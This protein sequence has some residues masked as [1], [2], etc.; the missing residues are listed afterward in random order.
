MNIK[1]IQ[2]STILAIGAL[3]GCGTVSD[4][5]GADNGGADIPG[6]TGPVAV[7]ACSN[8]NDP[9][10]D[11]QLATA[12][13]QLQ[14][15]MDDM[16]QA[17]SDGQWSQVQ[18]SAPTNAGASY[19]AIL[20]KYPG[21]CGAQFG[22]ALVTLANL[23]N[24]PDLDE[25]IDSLNQNSEDPS[26][27]QYLDADPEGRETVLL[28]IAIASNNSTP[29]TA[30]R[31]QE[32]AAKLMPSVDTAIALLDNVMDQK[33]FSVEFDYDQ[34]DGST[35]RVQ[36]DK[37]EVGPGLAYLKY[38]KAMLTVMIAVQVDI[39]VDGTY[40]W[41]KELNGIEDEDFDNLTSAQTEA[42]DYVL[43]L[44][45]KNSPFLN[46]RE[47]YRSAFAGIPALLESGLNDIQE[48]FQ[49]GIDEAAIGIAGQE[50]D[51]YVVGTWEDADVD[52]ADLQEGIQNLERIRK[53][54]KGP[55]T[56][57][58]GGGKSSLVVDA[59]KFFQI[60]SGYQDFLPYHSILPYTQWNDTIGMDTSWG[61]SSC[62]FY[63]FCGERLIQKLTT[64]AFGSETDLWDYSQIYLLNHTEGEQIATAFGISTAN[65]VTALEFETGFAQ[66]SFI[67]LKTPTSCQTSYLKEGE[68]TAH[69][70]TIPNCRMVVE[71]EGGPATP[72]FAWDVMVETRA[73]F[74][75]TDAN[76]KPT[77]GDNIDDEMDALYDAQGWAGFANK[78]I[79][80]DPT[81][82]GVFP[83][84]TQQT[85]WTTLASLEGIQPRTGC[86]V[87]SYTQETEGLPAYFETRDDYECNRYGERVIPTNPTDLD[88]LNYYFY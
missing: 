28:K 8:V 61:A 40:D 64:E 12:N 58:W 67:Y 21:H 66:Y 13:Q 11:S 35:R 31:V 88:V 27:D 85:V 59:T 57:T 19:N 1:A 30:S 9:N 48:G 14:G 29:M 38:M 86:K 80:P 25:V 47:N 56:L 37:G 49:Y 6:P 79:F 52:P 51:P 24:N 68:T 41:I 74:V 83:N 54:L 17:M 23:V 2:L 60:T 10:A 70:I 43:S 78:I 87:G 65:T 84:L 18:A 75:F 77:F 62:Y 72:E 5:P 22:K 46:I 20:S 36:I 26:I 73:P 4:S 16:V 76:G 63:G 34:D 82:G 55:V 15:S 44:T 50:N 33:D 71:Y 39:T 3:V 53:Y 42:L 45:K 81:F 7:S 32:V 69:T